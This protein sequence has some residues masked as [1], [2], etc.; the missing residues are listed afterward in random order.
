MRTLG[1]FSDSDGLSQVLLRL[2][3]TSTASQLE[4]RVEDDGPGFPPTMLLET[5]SAP[6]KIDFSSGS[7]GLGLYFARTVAGMHK[8]QDRQGVLRLENGG[9]WGGGCFILQLP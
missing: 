7:T 8:H 6:S 4:F 2:T 9:T 5:I 3:V 1:K